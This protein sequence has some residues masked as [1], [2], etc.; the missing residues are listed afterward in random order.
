MTNMS[1][2]KINDMSNLKQNK[3]LLF[4]EDCRE[5]VEYTTHKEVATAEVRGQEIEFVETVSRCNV[6]GCEVYNEAHEDINFAAIDHKY[7]ELNGIVTVREIEELMEMY[8]IK[9]RPLSLI[10]GFGEHTISQWLDGQMPQKAH[11]DVFLE[12][13]EPEIFKKYLEENH[14]KISAGAYARALN[15]V[16]SQIESCYCDTSKKIDMVA[17][18]ILSK[19]GDTTPL[20]LQK[21]LYYSQ[22][23]TKMF[24]E[25]FLFDDDCEAWVHG[26]VYREVY[27]HYKCY[28]FEPIKACLNVN[29][30]DML[31]STEVDII[32]SV[33]KN[34]GCYSGRI[35]EMM[36]HGEK[37]W[38]MTRGFL[39][40]EESSNDLI[41]KVL[42]EQ[43]FQEVKEK[44]NI[45][46]INDIADYSSD[47][48]KKIFS[49]N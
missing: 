7:R 40:S 35:L 9:K 3:D 10:L 45:I 48:F 37:P 11:S 22:A 41:D 12:A 14:E 27:H 21:L 38:L 32:E 39:K 46:E 18:M 2:E 24:T 6:C 16:N 13:K 29:Y 19:S 1:N 5:D 28:G 34:F 26:P 31:T 49:I 42:I 44:Y 17:K 36:T 23:F 25:N 47:L 43:Y 8:N 15:A 33:I 30:E 20:A 4:C